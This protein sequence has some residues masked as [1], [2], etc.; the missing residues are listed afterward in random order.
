VLAATAAK[1]PMFLPSHFTVV[2]DFATVTAMVCH[3]A[4]SWVL[5]RLVP[6]MNL[7]VP[8]VLS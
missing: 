7:L 1:L 4:G 3:L 5:P 6:P 8:D 2:P